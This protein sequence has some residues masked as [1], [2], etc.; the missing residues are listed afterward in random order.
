MAGLGLIPVDQVT[1]QNFTD[2]HSF[3]FGTNGAHPYGGLVLLG[4]TLYG[5]AADGGNL[6]V[7]FAVNTDG[8]G[9]TN[10][11][12]FTGS[13]GANPNAG[14]IL[15]GDTLFGTTIYGGSSGQGTVFAINMN[16]AGFTN[17]HSFNFSNG[18]RPNTG[19]VLS[20]NTLYGT[21]A[22]GGS[23]EYGTVFGINTNGTGFTNL[24]HF[25]GDNDGIE[26]EAGLILSGNTLFG[27]TYQGGDTGAGTIFSVRTDGTGFTNLFSF[28]NGNSGIKPMA[29]LLLSGSTLYGTAWQGGSS[30]KGTVFAVN[31]N[32]T[33]FT[34]LHS[35]TAI[36]GS[37]STNSDGGNPIAGLILSGST[38]YGTAFHGGSSGGGTV[39][40]INTDGTGFTVLFDFDGSGEAGG[41]RGSLILSGNTVYGTTLYGGSSGR[42]S[43]FSLS[44]PPPQLA[45]NSYGANVVL[46]WPT[47]APAVTLQSTTDII[48]PAVW[49]TVSPTPTIVDGQNA[50]TNSLSGTQKFYRL[51]Q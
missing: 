43:V 16:G 46:T 35:F 30:G 32:G 15:S 33:D 9:F 22:A 41:P 50:V 11:H 40:T 42:G 5:T 21:T 20:G 49:S 7:V 51:I 28:S 14:L 2:L 34:I 6:G 29:R 25:D 3:D 23:L 4:N 31:T 26:P 47:Y 13:D 48:S 27:T 24:Y 10:L 8:T 12:S 44:L 18:A 36:S 45:I 1:A 19:L 37:P 38:L 39:F 17:L